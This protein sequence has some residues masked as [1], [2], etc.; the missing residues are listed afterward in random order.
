MD[1]PDLAA[2]DDVVASAGLLQTS[3]KVSVVNA[4]ARMA[5]FARL[6]VLGLAIGTTY[7]GNTYE[8]ANW[9]PNIVFDLVAGGVLSAVFVPTFVSELRIG[10]ERAM[11]VASSLANIFLLLCIPIVVIGAIAAQPIMHLLTIAVSD[12]AVRAQQIRLGTFF[13]YFFLPQVPLYVL[14]MVFTGVL[15]A[16]RR[17]LAPAIA[18]L[19]SSLIVIG[20]YLWFGA[21]GAGNDLGKVTSLQK[22]ILAGGTTAGVLVLAFSQL[23]SVIASGVRWRPRLNWHDPSVR[24]AMRAGLAGVA[25]F[26][27]TEIGLLTTLILA[28]RVRGGVIAYRV[29]FAFF[30]LP[31][32]LIGLPIAA[33]LLPSLSERFG[34]KD[35]AGYAKLWSQGWHAALLLAAPAGAGLVVLAPALSKAILSHAP[36][37][38]APAL[39]AAALRTLAIGVPGY[40]LIEPLIRAFFARHDTKVPVLMNA[41]SIGVCV[42]FVVTLTAILRPHGVHALEIIGAAIALGH[43]CGAFIGAKVLGVRVSEWNDARDARFAFWCI[44]RAVVMSLVVFALLQK[45]HGPTTQTIVGIV[46]GVLVYAAL[47][48]PSA[49]LRETFVWLLHRDA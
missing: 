7:L 26:A 25:Y 5:G 2:A 38:A 20:A 22:F 42:A 32:A 29:A 8:S 4:F 39:V 19:C 14:A 45:I 36:S 27:L 37:T 11:D 41:V 17:F 13:L 23:P 24:R 30:D 46:A 12:P 21:L 34:R 40:L 3:A 31:H 16:H 18:P 10:R 49:Q 1:A 15:H 43:L 35:E 44:V 28:N 48:A 9:I 47:S 33:V 6:I